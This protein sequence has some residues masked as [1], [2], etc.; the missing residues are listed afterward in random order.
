M[1]THQLANATGGSPRRSSSPRRHTRSPGKTLLVAGSK[2]DPINYLTRG[3]ERA[4]DK[5]NEEKLAKLNKAAMK[6]CGCALI[7]CAQTTAL[8]AAE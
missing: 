4:R 3:G 1:T 8:L 7:V 6:V 5:L 2:Y